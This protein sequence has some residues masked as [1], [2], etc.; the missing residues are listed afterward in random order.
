MVVV[1][2]VYGIFFAW[3]DNPQKD[4]EKLQINPIPSFNFDQ[5]RHRVHPMMSGKNRWVSSFINIQKKHSFSISSYHHLPIKVVKQ[6]HV[7]PIIG[8]DTLW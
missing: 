5:L 3:L 8:S 2:V 7:R 1:I 6:G 4:A